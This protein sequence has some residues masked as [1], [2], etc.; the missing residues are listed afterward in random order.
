MDYKKR[1]R[2]SYS[3]GKSYK[4]ESNRK[5]RQYEKEEIRQAQ[6]EIL[7]G[8][9]FR[10]HISPSKV[11]SVNKEKTKIENLIAHKEK[12]LS[13]FYLKRFTPWNNTF[14]QWILDE[15]KKLKE[16]LK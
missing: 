2:K 7:E 4:K 9:E 5:E 13:F 1:A 12:F 14:Y 16:K 6:Q 3:A 15:I 10:Y 8:E 11:E